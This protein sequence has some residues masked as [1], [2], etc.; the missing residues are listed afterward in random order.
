MTQ[1]EADHS[2]MHNVILQAL[3]AV[4][5]IKPMIGAHGV[6]LHPGD[7][8]VLCSD[9]ICNMV[10]DA[11][12][13]EV[14]SRLPPQEACDT[15]IEA[16][17]EAGGHDNASLGIFSVRA[18]EE[19]KRAPEPINTP[20]KNSDTG[21]ARMT[22]MVGQYEI[23]DLLGEG[24]IGQVH[25]AF[26]T[27]LQREVAM[28]SL[29]PELLSD[30]NFVERFRSE[31]TSLARLNHPN[32]TTL[33]SLFPDGR[34][35]YMV[36]ELVRGTTLDSILE[37]RKVALD[38]R[39][40]L[41]IIAQAADG[42]DYAHS[43]GVIHRDIKPSNLIVSENGTLKIM[44][45]GIARVR[46]SQRLTRSGSIVGTLAYMAP[47]QLRGEEGDDSCDLYS[48]AIVLYE[49]LSGAPPFNAASEYDLMQAQINQKPD[50]LT[51]KVAGLDHE[52]REC[53]AQGAVEET[54]PALSVDEGLQR[55]ARRFHAADGCAENPAQRYAADRGPRSAGNAATRAEAAA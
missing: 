12:I 27:I 45:F 10:P 41:A 5:Q 13:A 53:P 36:M 39:E 21:S 51:P 52:D 17:L 4:P 49:M 54:G 46:G 37:K 38:I 19:T 26:D 32:I 11:K 35:L 34:N 7:V 40:C 50:R 1:D 22:R 24:G 18:A 44:D 23:R 6:P 8:L 47:E 33:Y 43:M 14:A 20:H 30:A 31:A 16:A 55:R 28:K 15:L 48:L 2:P 9:G 3:G 42:L 29:R 25:A